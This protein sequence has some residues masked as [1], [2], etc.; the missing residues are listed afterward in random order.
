MRSILPQSVFFANL[1]YFLGVIIFFQ[2]Q[3]PL[4]VYA[5]SH[6][7]GSDLDKLDLFWKLYKLVWIPTGEEGNLCPQY[8]PSP[9]PKIYKTFVVLRWFYPRL[10][11]S[12]GCCGG[13]IGSDFVA[14][15]ISW[16]I[17]KVMEHHVQGNTS[18]QVHPW[19]K[20][21]FKFIQL[22][23]PVQNLLFLPRIVIPLPRK[24]PLF[25]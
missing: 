7:L 13:K 8:H 2:V 23:N 16:H 12:Q 6:P 17:G 14:V 5:G 20:R 21:Q 9:D 1:R 11:L 3:A 19:E 4:S 18:I 10:Q 25:E 24:P 15:N 22:N